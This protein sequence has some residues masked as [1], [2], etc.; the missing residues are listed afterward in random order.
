VWKTQFN[1]SSYRTVTSS[2]GN[3][4]GD[5]AFAG[6]N[7]DELVIGGGGTCSSAPTFQSGAGASISS[8]PI[9]KGATFPFAGFGVAPSN[10]WYYDCNGSPGIGG[11]A[12]A[13]VACVK[14]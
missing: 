6:C 9:T 5:A 8:M 11:I 4:A 13:V 3:L 1:K 12:T 7:D 10:G 14:P 2:S